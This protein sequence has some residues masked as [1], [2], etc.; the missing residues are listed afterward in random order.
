MLQEDDDAPDKELGEVEDDVPVFNRGNHLLSVGYLQTNLPLAVSSSKDPN[1]S[2]RVAEDGTHSMI[3]GGKESTANHIV[4]DSAKD[5]DCGVQTGEQCGTETAGHPIPDPGRE[6][7]WDR[8]KMGFM[9]QL[10]AGGHDLRSDTVDL[11]ALNKLLSLVTDPDP[12]STS[13]HHQGP[14]HEQLTQSF[15]ATPCKQH[16]DTESEARSVG[17]SRSS[18]E[19]Q[20]SATASHL[21]S[22]TRDGVGRSQPSRGGSE[23]LLSTAK[24]ATIN[25]SALDMALTVHGP[26]ETASNIVSG[27][28]SQP[29]MAWG[30]ARESSPDLMSQLEALSSDQQSE[31]AGAGEEREKPPNETA[32]QS[33]SVSV[34]TINNPSKEESGE[35]TVYIDLRQ[36]PEGD[37]THSNSQSK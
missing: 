8:F 23:R 36:P 24:L 31:L 1:L 12:T 18:S 26:S 25:M 13:S 17:G 11:S 27:E 28:H 35:K 32:T 14:G 22:E 15:D 10:E 16:T 5:T 19:P 30:E 34:I 3:G 20:I 2:Q 4:V 21:S 9:E 6:L 7:E 37:T 29:N 33:D